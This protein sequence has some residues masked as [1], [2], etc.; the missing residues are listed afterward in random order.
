MAEAAAAG[1]EGILALHML[2]VPEGILALRVS[3]A[4]ASAPLGQ[5]PL[6]AIM[7]V[8]SAAFAALTSVTA[9]F[10]VSATL[11]QEHRATTLLALTALMSAD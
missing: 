5:V 3:A 6:A 7:F 9:K 1:A 2:V 4:L 10:V 8:I 11:A